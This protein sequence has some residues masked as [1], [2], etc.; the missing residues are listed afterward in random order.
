MTEIETESPPPIT[1]VSEPC[2]SCGGPGCDWCYGE[3]IVSRVLN[4]RYVCQWHDTVPDM[5]GSRIEIGCNA[6]GIIMLKAM[7]PIQHSTETGISRSYACGMHAPEMISHTVQNCGQFIEVSCEHSG[8]TTN[9]EP[10]EPEAPMLGCPE[11]A[12]VAGVSRSTA[13][14][15]PDS[16]LP[17]REVLRERVVNAADPTC[18]YDL[19][20][21]HTVM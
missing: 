3:P 5:D 12:I 10:Y 19:A 14:L 13:W 16:Q 17:Q 7:Y 20:C 1:F 4:G 21:G 9:G 15:M 11:C 6:I 8:F 2:E 18:V